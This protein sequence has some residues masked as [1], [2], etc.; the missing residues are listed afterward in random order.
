M[1][2]WE[3]R[4]HIAVEH[5]L[6]HTRVTNILTTTAWIFFFFFSSSSSQWRKKFIFFVSFAS[7]LLPFTAA[8]VGFSLALA[9]L[10]LK[11]CFATARATVSIGCLWA[12]EICSFKY[13]YIYYLCPCL[14]SL[15]FA[16]AFDSL[17]STFFFSYKLVLF[18]FFLIKLSGRIF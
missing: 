4:T 17:L 10:C 6:L 18:F 12:N 15:T 13:V 3:S 1:S 11:S 8:V 7:Y 5:K 9:A 2:K 16:F 14:L